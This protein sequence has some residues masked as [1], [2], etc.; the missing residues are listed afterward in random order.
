M[1]ALQSQ[2]LPQTTHE[3]EDWTSLWH[4]I[5]SIKSKIQQMCVLEGSSDI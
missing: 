2:N 5:D 3:E 1:D 4:A